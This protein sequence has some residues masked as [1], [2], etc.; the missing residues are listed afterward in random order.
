M[1]A[2]CATPGRGDRLFTGQVSLGIVAGGIITGMNPD[3][4]R[5]TS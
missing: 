4:G 1:G 3:N 2:G 5:N